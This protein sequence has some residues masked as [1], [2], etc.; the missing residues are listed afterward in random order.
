M[1]AQTALATIPRVPGHPIIGN[2]LDLQGE[3][4][5]LNL[6]E[7]AK[8]YGPIFRLE[9]GGRSLMVLSSYELVNEVCDDHRFDKFLGPG[10][11]QAR[12]VA[13]DGL[14]TAWSHEPNWKKAHNI[15]TPSFGSMAVR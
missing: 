14:F 12:M 4:P 13:G 15:L 8:I 1:A 10:L 9:V 7:L 11:L 2:M 6:V 5:L 3:T